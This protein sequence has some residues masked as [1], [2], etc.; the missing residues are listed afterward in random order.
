[1]F[2]L[3]VGPPVSDDG[4]RVPVRR[5]TGCFQRSSPIE[6]PGGTGPRVKEEGQLMCLVSSGGVVSLASGQ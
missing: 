5:R 3:S 2:S 6:T 1:M 4:R